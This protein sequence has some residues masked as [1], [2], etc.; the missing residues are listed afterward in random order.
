MLGAQVAL[1]QAALGVHGIAQLNESN[2]RLG[3]RFLPG[4]ALLLNADRD[5][6]QAFV[7]ERSLREGHLSADQI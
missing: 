4:I 6:Y 5:L 3:K 7:A 1:E 2:Q